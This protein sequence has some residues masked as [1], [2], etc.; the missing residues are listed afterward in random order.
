MSLSKAEVEILYHVTSYRDYTEEEKVM[1]LERLGLPPYGLLINLL[2][3]VAFSGD[4]VIDVTENATE[5]W[6][7][8]NLT[9]M[10]ELR[11]MIRH[12]KRGKL[13]RT[14]EGHLGIG[15]PNLQS[16]DLLCALD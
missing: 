8:R 6:K 15:P 12:V 11:N 2:L 9:T 5:F 10:S 3:M 7:Y 4:N 13:F 14:D 16:G 1:V